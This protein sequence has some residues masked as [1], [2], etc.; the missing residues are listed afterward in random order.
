MTVAGLITELEGR[1]ILLSLEGE[2]IRYRSPRQALTDAGRDALRAR[3][4]EIMDY[5]KARNAARGLRAASPVAGPLVPSVAQEMWRAFAGGADEG[6][7]VAL[8]IPTVGHFRAAPEAVTAAVH[9]LIARYDALRTRFESHDGTL[10]VFLNPAE[11]FQVEQEDLRRLSV[12]AAREAANRGAQQFCGLLNAIEG[13]WLV[14]AKVFALPEGE[15]LVAI[16]PAHMIADA[17]TRNIL[18]EEI[19]DILETGAPRAPSEVLYNDY[20][21]AEREFLAGEQGARLIDHWRRWYHDQPTMLAPSDKVPLTWGNGIR[22]VKNFI[23]PDR[24]AGK[25]RDLAA[26]L[27]VTPFLVYLT[28]FSMTMARWSKMEH[29]PLRVLGDKRVSL[30][31]SNT[32]GLMFCADAVEIHVPAEADFETVMRGILAE[33]DATLSLRI[34]TLHF[35][36]PHCVRPGIE[37]ADYPNKIPAVFNYYSLGTARERA[38]RHSA[39]DKDTGL[40]WPPDIATVTQT[41]PRRSSPLFW[42]LNDTGHDVL[43]SLHFFQGAV[44]PADQDSFTAMLFRVFADVVPG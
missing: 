44:S 14:R 34:P 21:L 43:A 20:A 30:E 33:Y 31:L 38:E 27:K 7:P 13:T 41:W 17:G 36:A 2:Q 6:K 26:S 29:F 37:A 11:T 32:V 28:I 24:V 9:K 42:H 40:P 15:C 39:S 3:R 19:H 16:S 18:L 35:W 8:N 10:L 23:I 4:D 1:G 5:L 12:D 25:V 22:I